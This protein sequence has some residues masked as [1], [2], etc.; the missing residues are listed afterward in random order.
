MCA[1][2][3]LLDSM[4]ISFYALIVIFRSTQNCVLFTHH[5]IEQMLHLKYESV[6]I[7]CREYI[8]KS[9]NSENHGGNTALLRKS[10]EYLVNGCS[11]MVTQNVLM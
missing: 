11:E 10:V 7:I 8:A 3:F 5:H 4:R 9:Q 6:A 1:C 2:V